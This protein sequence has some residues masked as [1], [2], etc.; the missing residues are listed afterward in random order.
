MKSKFS[1]LLLIFLLPALA[2][3]CSKKDANKE[4]VKADKNITE[5]KEVKEKKE[6]K[7]VS[8][9]SLNGKIDKAE[10]ILAN[11][12]GIYYKQVKEK[13]KVKEFNF[14]VYEMAYDKKKGILV[15][16]NKAQTLVKAVNINT[17][18]VLWKRKLDL[19]KPE[20]LEERQA[21]GDE[22]EYI[23]L[24]DTEASRDNSSPSFTYDGD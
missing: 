1:K 16:M 13:W 11:P 7:E 18:K 23:S 24:Q 19:K 20:K 12:K 9:S 22:T 4:D 21:E 8:V 15:G 3:S 2:I 5:K 6:I 10:V 14:S 17:G